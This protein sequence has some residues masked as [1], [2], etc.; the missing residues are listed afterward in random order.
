MH[1]PVRQLDGSLE[2]PLVG[3]TGQVVPSHATSISRLP[4]ERDPDICPAKA[5]SREAS[6]V[7][8]KFVVLEGRGASCPEA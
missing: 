8:G 1:T 6:F 2:E 5:A 3:K 7:G 4:V